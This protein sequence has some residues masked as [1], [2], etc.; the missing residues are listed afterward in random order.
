M[1]ANLQPYM[2]YKPSGIEHLGNVPA[3]WDVRTLGQIGR[4][5]KGTGGNKDDEVSRGIPCIR[6]GDLYTTHDYFIQRS[7]SFIAKEKETEYTTIELGDV[8]FAGSGETIDEIG[9]SAVNL[10]EQDACCGGD[11]ILCRPERQV[12]P[13]YLGY[14]TDCRPAVAQKATRVAA[15]RSCTSTER[16]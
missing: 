12:V 6:Y 8:L 7:R 16:S 15:S 4:L 9:K 14:A 5:L 3:H 1:N 2:N 13:R 11:I 10:I